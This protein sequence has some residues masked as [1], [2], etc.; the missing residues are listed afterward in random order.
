[1]TCFNFF[2]FQFTYVQKNIFVRM[3]IYFRA[4]EK[5]FPY[6]RKFSSN[7]LA[8]R[9]WNMYY[10]NSTKRYAFTYDGLNLMMAYRGKQLVNISE[11]VTNSIYS[12]VKNYSYTSEEYDYNRNGSMKYD[13]NSGISYIEYD[14]LNMPK[15]VIFR[16]GHVN[17]YTYD[18]KGRKLQVK[19]ITVRN[20]FSVSFGRANYTYDPNN[21]MREMSTDYCD[22]GSI[23]YEDGNLKMIRTEEGYLTKSGNTYSHHLYI[24]DHLGNNC[25]TIAPASGGTWNME[26]EMSYFSFGMPYPVRNYNPERQPFLFA[27]K[28][29]DEMHG[30]NWSDF[31]A[32]QKGSTVPVF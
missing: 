4:Y 10:G 11:S 28:E 2:K 13:V 19:H 16:K 23:I 32:R 25:S 12:L 7:S 9:G 22:G 26:Q 3:K 8:I 30:L 15:Q 31:I 27:D 21:V 24:K 14:V 29:L 20:E 18:S 1:M 5:I 17:L 6:V